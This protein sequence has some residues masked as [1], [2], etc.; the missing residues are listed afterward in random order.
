MNPFC[1]RWIALAI[2]W[3]ALTVD[4]K[5]FLKNKKK[6]K[7]HTLTLGHVYKQVGKPRQC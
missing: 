7:K 6:Y 5:V 4:D 1:T 2:N 3:H